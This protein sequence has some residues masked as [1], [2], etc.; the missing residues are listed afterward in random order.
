MYDMTKFKTRY[1]TM[2]LRNGKVIDIMP[3]KLKILKKISR[4]SEIKDKEEFSSEDM[5]N[6]TEAITLAFNKN[7]QN[8]KITAEQIEQEYDIL[9]IVDFLQNYFTWINEIQNIKN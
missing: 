2:R 7:K 3:P 4:L 8:Y 9:Q 1:F 5:Q 6:L